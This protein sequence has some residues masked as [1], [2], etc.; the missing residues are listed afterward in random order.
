MKAPRLTV[1]FLL[2]GAFASALGAGTLSFDA[3][4]PDSLAKLLPSPKF[5]GKA[6]TLAILPTN[7][8]GLHA[9][10]AY[11]GESSY[12]R[13]TVFAPV[14]TVNLFAAAGVTI[15]FNDVE[16]ETGPGNFNSAHFGLANLDTGTIT[17]PSGP[18]CGYFFHFNQNRGTLEF[19]VFRGLKLA[20]LEEIELNQVPPKFSFRQLRMTIRGKRY[21]LAI[22]QNSGGSVPVEIQ[23]EFAE[24]LTPAEWGLSTYVALQANAPYDVA[25]RFAKLVV[26]DIEY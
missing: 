10:L 13:A 5:T 1:L 15:T 3:K 7:R 25:E 21:E 14:R 11:D 20:V 18:S 22:R 26:G 19:G 9:Q 8:V 16:L 12:A 24:P 23:G 2:A 6:G 17:A 4:D